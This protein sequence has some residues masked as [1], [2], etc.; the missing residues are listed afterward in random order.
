MCDGVKS[1]ITEIHKERGV[2][3][4]VEQR[5][6][7][8]RQQSVTKEINSQGKIYGQQIEAGNLSTSNIS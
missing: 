1:G 5:R 3:S 8:Q 4:Q 6:N 2:L 7:M